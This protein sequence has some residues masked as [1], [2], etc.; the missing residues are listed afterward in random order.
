MSETATPPSPAA[1]AA[2]VDHQPPETFCQFLARTFSTT[3]FATGSVPEAD[4]LVAASDIVLTQNDVGSPFTILCLIDREADPERTFDLPLG[5][6]EQI[7]DACTK[8][9]HPTTFLGSKL[10]VVIRVIEVGPTTDQRWGQLKAL[11]SPAPETSRRITALAVD[12]ARQDIRGNPAL[13]DG[14]ERRFVKELLRACRARDAAIEPSIELP[15]RT[16]PYLTFGMIA[17]LCLVFW[18]ELA[19]A[20]DKSTDQLEPSIKTLISLGGLQWSLAV[21]ENQW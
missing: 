3:G 21:G 15:T 12:P 14:L 17:A 18:G 4:A 9:S 13:D 7:A 20:V 16:V 2:P 19:F 1:S 8:Y 5:R 6:L 10:T 11:T